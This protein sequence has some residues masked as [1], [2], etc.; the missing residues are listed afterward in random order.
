M[1]AALRKGLWSQ[2]IH[3]QTGQPVDEG[4]LPR[5]TLIRNSR[6]L[7]GELGPEFVFEA[8]DDGVHWY[9]HRTYDNPAKYV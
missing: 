6:V 7:D 4:V 3:G 1:A 5:G 8:S 9:E 2:G